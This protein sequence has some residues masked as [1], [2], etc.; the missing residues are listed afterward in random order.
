MSSNGLHL[1]PSRRDQYEA[2]QISS[3][4]I[5]V[6]DSSSSDVDSDNDLLFALKKKLVQ[7]WNEPELIT[8]GDTKRKKSEDTI[9]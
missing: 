6:L 5:T 9:M 3:A 8:V 2:K 7:F 1:R 4:A